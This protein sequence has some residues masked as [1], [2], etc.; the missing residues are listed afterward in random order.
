MAQKFVRIAHEIQ[1]QVY[2]VVY[3]FIHIYNFACRTS[4]DRKLLYMGTYFV[5]IDL[6]YTYMKYYYSILVVK[7]IFM[8]FNYYI[9]RSF[10]IT[11]MAV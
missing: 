11:D 9:V 5:H 1:H 10:G 3:K 8:P 2:I 6:T 7:L 4:C